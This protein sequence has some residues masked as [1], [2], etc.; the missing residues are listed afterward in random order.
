MEAEPFCAC[1]RRNS[2]GRASHSVD[3]RRIAKLILRNTTLNRLW[4]WL[5]GPSDGVL[6]CLDSSQAPVKPNRKGPNKRLLGHMGG[7][8]WGGGTTWRLSL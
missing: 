4:L 8:G 7:G 3:V 6:L 2:K 5:P 1:E